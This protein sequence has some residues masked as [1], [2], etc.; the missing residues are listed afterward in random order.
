MEYFVGLDIG[1]SSVKGVLMSRD[2]KVESVKTKKHA[3]YWENNLKLLNADDFCENCFSVIKELSECVAA[4]D[5]IAGVC[6]SGAGGNLMLVKDGKACSPV[7]GWQTDY[8]EA[9]IETVLAPLT[10]EAV[11]KTVGWPKLNSF[12]L[13][14][15]GYLKATEPQSLENADTVCM[16]IEYLN[17]KLTGVWGITRSQGTTFYLIDQAAGKY[18]KEH[19]DVFGLTEDKLPPIVDACSVLGTITAEAAAKTGLA[20]GTPVIPGTFD[21]PSAARGAGV[22]DESSVMVSCGTSW[23]VFIPYATRDIPYSKGIL[24]DPFM[25]PKGNWCGMKS[26]T[27][28]AETIDAYTT[29]FLGD[30]HV[31]E[32]DRLAAEA[33][34]GCNGLVIEDENTDVTGY[35]R[36]DIARA[37]MENIARRLKAF[38]E[39]LE[40]KADVVKLVGGITNSKPWCEVV[41]Q[42][43]GKK[44]LVINGEHAGAI[45]S[46]I[47]AGVGVGAYPSEK[48][49]FTMLGFEK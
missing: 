43:T 45:G 39:E 14:A 41:G 47:M 17:Y 13:A 49:A 1:T 5:R 23:V 25:D 38:L 6:V 10:P 22:L 18:S 46:A 19:L 24:V 37:I 15:L 36:A 31:K 12:P 20:E 8:D 40:V 3:Y 27:S 2:G 26:M 30:I 33:K 32:F 21:H 4:Q 9:T 7:Y 34:L 35:S 11:Y 29:H 16:H 48:E 28:V 44:V 42:I